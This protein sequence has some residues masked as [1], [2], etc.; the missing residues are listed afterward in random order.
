MLMASS[1]EALVL[2]LLSQGRLMKNK[3]ISKGV[4]ID[5]LLQQ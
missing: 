3:D 5:E 2:L 4:I 1:A